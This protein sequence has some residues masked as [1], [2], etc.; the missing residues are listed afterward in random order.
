MLALANSTHFFLPSELGRCIMVNV[1]EALHGI[2]K[3]DHRFNNQ[4]KCLEPSAIHSDFSLQTIFQMMVP[5]Q[6]LSEC[7]ED[8]H[9]HK[10]TKFE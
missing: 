3:G 1:L 5:S 9:H 6:N 8:I 7:F 4:E 2:L 10:T